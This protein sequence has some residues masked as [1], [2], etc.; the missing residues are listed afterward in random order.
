MLEKNAFMINPLLSSSRNH[1][2]PLFHTFIIKSKYK[3]H[4]N[5]DK[6]M[7]TNENKSKNK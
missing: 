5:N 7:Q 1:G 4:K 6:H 3:K 2:V